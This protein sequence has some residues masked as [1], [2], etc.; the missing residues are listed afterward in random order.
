[1]GNLGHGRVEQHRAAEAVSR[2][3]DDLFAILRGG[4]GIVD[5]AAAAQ[6][7]EAEAAAE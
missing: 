6:I 2:A 7:G 5:D 4:A 3:V 1:M